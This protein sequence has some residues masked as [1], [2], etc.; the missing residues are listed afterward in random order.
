MLAG[1]TLK[2]SDGDYEGVTSDKIHETD[3]DWCAVPTDGADASG[4][5]FTHG[6]PNG[7]TPEQMQRRADRVVERVVAAHKKYNDKVQNEGLKEPGGDVRR[8][9]PG[10]TDA[11]RC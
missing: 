10:L 6:C 5:I 9:T 11:H 8:S 2:S 4:D 7:E 3:P 1:T